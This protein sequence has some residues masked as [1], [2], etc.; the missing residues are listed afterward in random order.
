MKLFFNIL[1]Y[2]G[3]NLCKHQWKCIYESDYVYYNEE[4]D[5]DH[6]KPSD[7][8]KV[9]TWEC[10]KCGKIKYITHKIL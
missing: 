1:K 9:K 2:F 7:I 4:D 5:R 3:F 8:Y 10:Q 6:S